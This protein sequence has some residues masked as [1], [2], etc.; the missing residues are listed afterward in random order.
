M[1]KGI[2][3]VLI[4]FG[5][6]VVCEDDDNTESQ[7]YFPDTER[8]NTDSNV[9][10]FNLEAGNEN[11]E[12]LHESVEGKKVVIETGSG[13]VQGVEIQEGTRTFNKFLGIPFAE[14][15]VGKRRFQPPVPV[16]PWSGQLEATHNGPA[17]VQMVTPALG[18][19]EGVSENCL[20]QG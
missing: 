16:R 6:C 8:L 3:C 4:A 13:K 15:P 12:K 2:V 9:E 11:A 1:K 20:R 18:P 7:T 10:E 17:C 14:P 5:G 19:N